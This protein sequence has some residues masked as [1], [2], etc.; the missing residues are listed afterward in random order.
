MYVAFTDT[1]SRACLR[2][3]AERHRVWHVRLAHMSPGTCR[4]QTIE[5]TIRTARLGVVRA[6]QTN[7]DLYAAIDLSCD[8]V[9]RSLRK[10]KEKAIGRGNW[11][12]RAGKGAPKL[13]EMMAEPSDDDGVAV[14][15]DDEVESVTRKLSTLPDNVKK[16]K[17][18]YLDPMS[19]EVRAARLVVSQL[20]TVA[21]TQGP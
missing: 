1:C 7:D 15:S 6:E 10:L 2:M 20:R 5:L 11:P 12:G 21:L 8:K 3:H 17:V 9:A 16:T 4:Q 18:F 14:P 19:V 13:A